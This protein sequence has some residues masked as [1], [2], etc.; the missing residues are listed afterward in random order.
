MVPG[1]N[2]MNSKPSPSRRTVLSAVVA[3]SICFTTIVNPLPTTAETGQLSASSQGVPPESSN[4]DTQTDED[5][6][7]PPLASGDPP[8]LEPNPEDTP[9]PALVLS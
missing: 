2:E 5:N 6:L 4:G 8:K 7:T 3:L 1:V 9:P